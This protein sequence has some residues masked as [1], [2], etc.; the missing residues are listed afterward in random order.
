MDSPGWIRIWSFNERMEMHTVKAKLELSGIKV[1]VVEHS[2]Y[3]HGFGITPID[4]GQLHVYIDD[5]TKT[6]KIMNELGYVI[7]SFIDKEQYYKS[8]NQK[9]TSSERN[10]LKWGAIV[11]VVI[12]VVAI[13]V[14]IM[15]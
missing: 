7:P 3:R 10:I 5:Y 15:A 8:L 14:T 9:A 1:I 4:Q 11:L 13:I 6:A 12:V 2:G